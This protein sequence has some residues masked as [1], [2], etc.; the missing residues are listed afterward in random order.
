MTTSAEEEA[1]TPSAVTGVTPCAAQAQG[2]TA[3]LGAS[4]EPAGTL[5]E[6]RFQYGTSTSYGSETKV[7]KSESAS[8][9]LVSQA[10]VGLEPNRAYD[11]RLVASDAEGVT[12]GANGTFTTKALPPKIVS[13]LATNVESTSAQL[14]ATIDP[15]NSP[16]TYY[17]EYVQAARYHPAAVDPYEEG[18]KTPAL[19]G[20]VGSELGYHA[21]AQVLE[22]LM[23]G[24]TYDFRV[25]ASN[26]PEPGTGTSYGEDQTFTP[27]GVNAPVVGTGAA[28]AVSETGATL[29]GTVDPEGYATSYF[30]EVG[31]SAG[32]GTDISG[33]LSGS[34]TEAQSVTL[35]LANLAPLTTYHYRLSA[36]NA[37]GTSYGAD[38]AFTT[39][40]TAYSLTLPLTAPLL[41][42]PSIAFPTGSQA[43]TQSPAIE[44][45]SHKVKGRT[46]TI[47]VGVPS[48]GK[49]TASG[50]GLT[51]ASKTAKGQEDVTIK[52]TQKKAGKLK[53]SVK[54]VFTPTHGK[55]QS[56]S[57]TVHFRK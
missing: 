45:V 9:V 21:V 20:A 7:Q 50:K 13:E 24:T 16:T 36:T 19:E 55:K 57:V 56:K 1:A 4:F 17:M 12:D 52:L 11:C 25:V 32:Y 44:V 53:T 35:A 28:S 47:K 34:G 18:V 43:N 8:P 10:T 40:G 22:G 6:Y 23:P 14:Q 38:Q 31:T 39:P 49:V 54:V 46:A 5:T 2:E 37:N 42:T 15:E 27:P 3:T 41:T 29:S 30:F 33:T 51:T 26:S 48:A